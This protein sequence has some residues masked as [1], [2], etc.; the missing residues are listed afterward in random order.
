MFRLAVAKL[1]RPTVRTPRQ[2]L[3]NFATPRRTPPPAADSFKKGWL[4][5]SGTYPIIVT[6]SVALV[7]V[8]YKIKHDIMS[9]EAHFSRSE[10]LTLDYIENERAGLAEATSWTSHRTLHQKK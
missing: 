1:T 3:R 5:D 2:K 7:L 8:A 6:I 10:R 4:N 9:P